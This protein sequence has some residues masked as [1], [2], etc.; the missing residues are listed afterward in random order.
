MTKNTYAKAYTE[1]LELL[2]YLPDE[3]YAK[4]PKEK[5]SY[6]EENSDKKYNFKID[7]Q[8]NIEK[9]SISLEAN[10]II[11][12]LFREYFANKRQKKILNSLL[13][14]NQS[15]GDN[16]KK[17]KYN[18]LFKNKRNNKKVIVDQEK[19]ENQIIEYKENIFTKIKKF[20][21]NI[22]SKE[23]KK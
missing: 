23:M 22:F 10:T 1:V 12:Q 14:Q 15:I 5:I 11:I 2:K 7:S 19:N 13:L 21:Y 6:F 3:E 20:I 17:E 4:I 9:Q 16:R 18:D 8:L